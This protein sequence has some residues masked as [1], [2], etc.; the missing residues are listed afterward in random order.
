MDVKISV[1]FIYTKLFSSFLIAPARPDAILQALQKDIVM[2]CLCFILL[3]LTFVSACA[4]QQRYGLIISEIMADPSPSVGLPAYEWIELYNRSDHDIDLAGMRIGDAT[5][6]SNALPSYQLAAGAYVLV[7]SSTAAAALRIYGSAL[8]VTSFPSLDND[9]DMVI[10]KN[11]AGVTL[12]AVRYDLSWYGAALK[13]EGGWTLEIIDPDKPCLGQGNWAASTASAGGTPGQRNAV[14][15]ITSD[16]SPPQALWSIAPESNQLHIRFNETLDSSTASSA[17]HYHI[18][19]YTTRQVEIMAPLFDQAVVFITGSMEEGK[20]YDLRIRNIA[21]CAGNVLAEQ[22]IRTGKATAIQKGDVVL[23]EILFNPRS[24]GQDY[25]EL[26]NSSDH[27][28]DMSSLYLANRN[29]SGQPANMTRLSAVRQPVFP[30]D[31]C[32]FTTDMEALERHYSVRNKSA[33]QQLSSLPSFPNDK[34]SVL[35]LDEQG[36]ILDELNYEEKWHFALLNEYKGVALERLS[37]DRPAGEQSNWH[38]A[39]STAGYGTP[40]YVN[41]QQRPG[42]TRGEAQI[43]LDTEIFSPDQ[44]GWQDLLQICYQLPEPGSVANVYVFD[45]TGIKVR[46]LVRNGTMGIQGCWKWD[47]LDQRM[48]PLPVGQYVVYVEWFDLKGRRQHSKKVVILAGKLR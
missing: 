17:E 44:D 43:T 42:A 40:G 35:L 32:V 4:A 6:T 15:G 24:G 21:D 41:S 12:H 28:A 46:H 10:L 30:G 2:R 3:L 26:Y 31:Y 5:G 18:E 1:G 25:V 11:A 22:T 45:D 33:V 34:G 13:K 37:P 27:I 16:E 9:G 7:G 8:G 20:T 38:S 29:S 23:N 48:Q 36:V 19:G 47:G 14:H 39:A